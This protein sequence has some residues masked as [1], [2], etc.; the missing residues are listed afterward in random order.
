MTKELIEFLIVE[1][2]YSDNDLM[3]TEICLKSGIALPEQVKKDLQE[4][5]R[6][7]LLKNA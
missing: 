1:K 7:E 5:N 3:L 2:K 6:K 4:F